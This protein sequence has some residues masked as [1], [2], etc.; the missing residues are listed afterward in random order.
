MLCLGGRPPLCTSCYSIVLQYPQCRVK[1]E[2][3]QP[4]AFAFSESYN[5]N[6]GF[7]GDC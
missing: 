5:A 7:K 6:Q 1:L 3:M 2:C 4:M